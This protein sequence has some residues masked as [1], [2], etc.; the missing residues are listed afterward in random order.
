MN[1]ADRP[2]PMPKQESNED[3]EN[4]LRALPRRD[5]AIEI[6]KMSKVG[7]GGSHDVLVNRET[8]DFVLKID[9]ALLSRVSNIAEVTPEMRQ[10]AQGVISNKE[11]EHAAICDAFGRDHCLAEKY[12]LDKVYSES[13]NRA[14]DT[15]L[16]VQK[17]SEAFKNPTKVDFS[18]T[19]LDKD[20]G[21]IDEAD[22]T[23]LVA[24][25]EGKDFDE[26]VFLKYEKGFNSIFEK[27][28]SDDAFA[29]SLSDFVERFRE[30]Y[31][32]N[33]QILD[34]VGNENVLLYEENGEWK[35]QVGTVFKGNNTTQEF[36]LALKTL[37]TTPQDF[38]EG[39]EKEGVFYNTLANARAINATA[40]KLGLPPVFSFS[41]NEN[42][43]SNLR[44]MVKK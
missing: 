13:E 26:S 18:A 33:Q 27:I 22:Y 41:L 35:Y 12:F 23:K 14:I 9:R 34:F 38:N 28:D 1:F 25:A 42:G 21:K 2:P 39:P 37:E 7:S 4:Y 6:N 5:D 11:K 44:K 3:F 36:N 32:K 30:Y 15:I 20:A 40:H 17:K 16:T 24:M 31:A 8:D 29:K 43:I 19:Y 10:A